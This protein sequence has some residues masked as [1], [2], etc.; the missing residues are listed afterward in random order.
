M[1]LGGD[2]WAELGGV[3]W[4]VGLGDAE[5]WVGLG[6]DSSQEWYG[7]GSCPLQSKEEHVP[8]DTGMD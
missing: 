2:W 7:L 5:C 1:G 3:D 4:C 8:I 6:V